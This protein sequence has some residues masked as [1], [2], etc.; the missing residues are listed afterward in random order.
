M[1]RRCE[2][3]RLGVG[4]GGLRVA[5]YVGVAVD[6]CELVSVQPV[7][8]MSACWRAVGGRR[9]RSETRAGGRCAAGQT[10]DQPAHGDRCAACT[11]Q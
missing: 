3:T 1:F 2:Q 8:R 11:V 9:R 5:V 6:E 4:E 10:P 7:S